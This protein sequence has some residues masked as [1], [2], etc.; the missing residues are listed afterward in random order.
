MRMCIKNLLTVPL[1]ILSFYNAQAQSII[2]NNQ[3]AQSQVGGYVAAQDQAMNKV[4]TSDKARSFIAKLN[5]CHK[6]PL[7]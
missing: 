3:A 6:K 2:G 7:K 5:R 1:S 4:K